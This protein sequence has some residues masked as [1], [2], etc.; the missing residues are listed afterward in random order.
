MKKIACILVGGLLLLGVSSGAAPAA[1]IDLFEYAFNLDGNVVSSDSSIDITGFDTATG[2][3]AITIS[4]A[5]AGSHSIRGF[6]D[7]E[8]YQNINTFF[9]EVGSVSGSV[10]EGQSWEIDEP[11][12]FFGDIYDHFSDSSLSLDNSNNVPGTAP[13]DVSMA[14]GWLFDLSADQTAAITFL[15]SEEVP[16]SGFYLAQFDPNSNATIYFSSSLQT[17]G[18]PV[19]EPASLLL[20]G[21]GLVACAGWI[22]RKAQS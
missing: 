9:N 6:F 4:I 16:T 17:T 5:T 13:D 1:T 19:P 14:M 11:G 12:Y 3:G 8:I 10:A 2:L 18:T 21:S 20:F 15:L 7:H 22:R